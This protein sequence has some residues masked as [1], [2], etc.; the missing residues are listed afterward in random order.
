MNLTKE[1]ELPIKNMAVDFGYLHNWF[2][3]SVG[4]EEPVWTEDH[5]EE[6]L[7]EFVV[8]PKEV[9]SKR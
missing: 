7:E 9:F 4:T 6:L 1:A 2:I 3:D 5:I 8:I